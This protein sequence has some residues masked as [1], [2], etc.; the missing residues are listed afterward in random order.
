MLSGMCNQYPG[1]KHFKNQLDR[2]LK[3]GGTWTREQY[4]AFMRIV[5]KKRFEEKKDAQS[6]LSS[7]IIDA[8]DPDTGAGLTL[9]EIWGESRML[10]LAGT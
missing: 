5:V 3:P 6:D 2:I 10:M 9:T 7:F 8:K 4:A 1:L